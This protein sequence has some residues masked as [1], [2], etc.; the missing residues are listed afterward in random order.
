MCSS[1]KAIPDFPLFQ[2]WFQWWPHQCGGRSHK[3][4]S[5]V[6]KSCS[7][8]HVYLHH[9]AFQVS[10]FIQSYTTGL[11]L[12][13]LSRASSAVHMTFCQMPKILHKSCQDLDPDNKMISAYISLPAVGGFREV[14]DLS[15]CVCYWLALC[16]LE[17]LRLAQSIRALC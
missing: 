16:C 4:Q 15:H 10:G 11:V 2:F 12:Q 17:T 8:A 13:G 14:G 9:K 7:T 3:C 6:C 1:N 5:K